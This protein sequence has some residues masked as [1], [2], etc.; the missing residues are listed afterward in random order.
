MSSSIEIDGRS[1]SLQRRRALSAG[2]AALPP[3]AERT[4][5]GRRGVAGPTVP[6]PAPRASA[7]APVPPPSHS[8]PAPALPLVSNASLSGRSVSIERR[9]QLSAGKTSANGAAYPSNGSAHPKTSSN[10]AVENSGGNAGPGSGLVPVSRPARELAQ[11]RRAELSLHGRGDAPAAA[12]I[13]PA[14]AGKIEYPVR[15]EPSP[16]QA[17]RVVTGLRISPGNAVTGAARGSAVPVSGSQYIAADAGSG[18]RA[19]GPKVGLS[20]TSGGLVVS[21][22]LVRSNVH[23]TGDEAGRGIAITGEADQRIDDDLT[24]RANNGVSAPSQFRRQADPHGTSVHG[25]NLGRSLRSAGS[26]ER[27]RAEIV[28]FSQGGLPVTGS[29]IG[30]STRVSGDEAGVC[31]RV[32]GDQYLS[33]SEFQAECGGRL[34]GTAPAPQALANRPDPV[35]GAKV[36]TSQTWGGQRV[37]GVDVEHDPR[38][39][40]DEPGSCKTITGSAY[41]GTGTMYAYCDEDSAANAE[42][43]LV[44]GTV[45]AAVTGDTPRNGSGVTG[46]SRGA[47]RSITGTPYFASENAARVISANPVATIDGQFS[48]RS[49]QRAAQLSAAPH[50][51]RITGSFAGGHGKVTGNLEFAFRNRKA[52][53][54]QPAAR[55]QMTGEGIGNNR[56]SGDSYKDDSRVTGTGTRVETERNPTERGGKPRPF[57]GAQR[58]KT[59]ASHE[60]PKHL[61]TGMF[62]YS[63]DSGAKVTLSGGAQG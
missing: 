27:P 23:V 17:G 22:T 6:A 58:F 50:P 14:R 32:T 7:A 26:R 35:T 5:A 10:A 13:R 48:V 49:P 47:T 43:R 28:E 44:R 56:I 55:I 40:G 8:A 60:E 24:Q 62:G 11:A 4:S 25:T 31:R 34:G 30:R 52:D 37:S 51:E 12:P 59:L 33:P 20:R 9:R 16:T 15:I 46:T 42:R 3:A 36:R 57:A 38:V 41:Q 53:D 2:K 61:V 54:A 45:S 29:A 21:G 1:A 18:W 63:S 39:T 19:G